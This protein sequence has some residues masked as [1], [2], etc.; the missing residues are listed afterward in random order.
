MCFSSIYSPKTYKYLGGEQYGAP[1]EGVPRSNYRTQTDTSVGNYHFWCVER[2]T[3]TIVDNTPPTL[4]PD[5]RRIRNAPLY[6][7]W[8][9]DF[10]DL[11]KDY[12]ID[13]FYRSHE[14]EMVEDFLQNVV[15]NEEWEVKKC[16]RNSF[17]L[18]KSDPN[19]YS[20]VCGSFGW[21]LD[22]TDKN[23]VIGLDY[24]Y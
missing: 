8:C 18:W 13:N 15:E 22:E 21:V 6:I 2:A 1:G 16:F 7:P 20:L 3:T 10:Q 11:Q 19:K 9:K 5:P 17:A 24:G 4:P 12:C 14:V 23:L